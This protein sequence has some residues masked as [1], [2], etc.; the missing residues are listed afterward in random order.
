MP[1]Q[2]PSYIAANE[3]LWTFDDIVSPPVEQEDYLLGHAESVSNFDRS[4]ASS[5]SKLTY[6]RSPHEYPMSSNLSIDGDAIHNPFVLAGDIVGKD[7]KVD[8]AF[9]GGSG[10]S[11]QADNESL[12]NGLKSPTQ[13]QEVHQYGYLLFNDK[14]D[15]QQWSM[16]D[17]QM[18][19][20][21]E[22]TTEHFPEVPEEN[23][24]PFQSFNLEFNAANAVPIHLSSNSFNGGSISSSLAKRDDPSK[25]AE[26]M[27]SMNAASRTIGRA[28]GITLPIASP[29][30]GY[31]KKSALPIR[32]PSTKAKVVGTD[33]R[34][35]RSSLNESRKPLSPTL[36]A[37]N[38]KRGGRIKGLRLEPPKAEQ[39]KRKRQAK[40]TCIRCRIKRTEASDPY[41]L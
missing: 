1:N 14:Q 5:V 11:Y 16:N 41:N 25:Q 23:G 38:G 30:K 12:L 7:E 20:N 24:D 19:Q 34:S 4:R 31:T 3:N 9:A 26:D 33:K 2:N 32:S 10:Y 39:I 40:N 22:I 15:F 6:G 8:N 37:S 27:T 36:L 18:D 21:L 28:R 35:R 29:L 17:A 13:Q